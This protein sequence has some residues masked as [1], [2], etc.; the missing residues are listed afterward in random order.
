MAPTSQTAPVTLRLT[1]SFAAPREKVFR[2]WTDPE[3]LK[4]W[5]APGDLTT[6]LAEVDLRV[7]GRYRIHMRTPD[8]TAHKVTGVYQTV[9]PP[10]RL[11]Y[12]WFWE[13]KPEQGDTLVTVEFHERG[14]A[15]EV[16]LTHERF[17]SGDVRDRHEQGWMGC[18]EKLGALLAS[19]ERGS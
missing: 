18:L 4:Q 17:P 2:A 1:R 6:P 10:R 19:A 15:T 7:G 8:G 16:T 13:N 11:V 5:A 12:T 14:S 9:D 3:A